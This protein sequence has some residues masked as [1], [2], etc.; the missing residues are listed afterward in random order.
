MS[1]HLRFS[2]WLRALVLATAAVILSW[3]YTV[4][5]GVATAALGAFAGTLIGE[6]ASRTRVRL[7]AAL[8]LAAA[9]LLFGQALVR[10]MISSQG[11]ADVVGPVSMLWVSEA[12]RWLG[13]A[14]PVVFAL[15]FLAAR[16]PLL[17]LLEV[18]VVGLAFAS[19]LAAHRDG[20][21]HRPLIFGDWAWTRG[22]DPALVFLFL[23]G[24]GTLLLAALLLAEDRKR[25]LP[26]HLAAL[27]AVALVLFL[28]VR[29]SGLP[30]PQ[31]ASD[32]GLT[33]EGEAEEG[34]GQ[35]EGQAGGENS[36]QLEDLEFKNE[37]SNSGGEAP[38]A[39]VLL[40][41]DYSP[42][43]GVYYFRQAAFSQYNGRR[44]VT[45]MRDDVD[46]DVLR[47]FPSQRLAVPEVP[48]TSEKRVALRTS[49]GLLVDHVKPFALDSP[50]VYQPIRNPNPMRFQRAFEALSHVRVLP[51]SLMLG[52]QPG[53]RGWDDE[54]W[55]HYT[56]APSDPR[57][58]QLADETL[59]VLRPEYRGDPLAQALAIKGYLDDNGIYSRRSR[60]ADSRDPAASFLFGDLTG[61]CVHFAH[62]ATYLFRS[63]GLP[64][65]VAAGYAVAES[66][67]G[68]GSTIMIRGNNAHA[69]P[70]I[71]LDGIGW[72]VV[73]LTPAQTLD[74]NMTPPDQA[75]QRMLGEM[76]REGARQ[77]VEQATRTQPPSLADVLAWILRLLAV[78]CLIG[79]TIKLYRGLVPRFASARQLYRVGYRAALDRLAE[80]GVKRR[81]GESR[82]RFAARSGRLS[83]AF[84][85]LTHDHLRASLGGRLPA[86][87]ETFRQLIDQVGR[88]LR[89]Q[90]P[91]WRRVLGWL[92]PFSWMT[93][94]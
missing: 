90:V 55:R 34:E 52:Q 87:P 33:G 73:D 16:R 32:L 80:V 5:A 11:L 29:V 35:G 93:A 38:V 54:Q 47:R 94:R 53:D 70:E 25:R 66:D 15:R 13:L 41:D 50:A 28:F 71:F 75:L 62:A 91:A 45:A 1:R 42:P 17:A 64:A 8:A 24:L 68:T 22:F 57:Y 63:I 79:L 59:A 77:P 20:M 18:T 44:L 72:V 86:E 78:L 85:P 82:E 84:I 65:R 2:T 37:Y 26:L 76:M 58:R 48:P 69:W 89:Q 39:V 14:L 6:L 67:R 46:R 12:F 51:Y 30:Q 81:F 21:V 61:Y 7:P 74:P 31:P 83:P 4:G 43:S 23:G 36:D 88:D 3:P 92:H 10:V 19:S 27:V 9:A 49:M 40:H 60:H 56:E